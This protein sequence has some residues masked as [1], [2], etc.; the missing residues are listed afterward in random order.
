MEVSR[1]NS[2]INEL[3][4]V[5]YTLQ[6]QIDRHNEDITAANRDNQRLL[7]RAQ[8]ETQRLTQRLVDAEDQLQAALA[9]TVT[10]EREIMTLQDGNFKRDRQEKDE[11]MRLL[12]FQEEHTEQQRQWQE[13][14]GSQQPL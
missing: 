7:D 10:L 5:N 2:R 13:Q 8:L 6:R 1:L 3:D 14:R 9:K 11:R 4:G 12:A